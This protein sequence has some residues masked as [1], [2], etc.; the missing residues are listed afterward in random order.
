VSSFQIVIPMSGFGERFRRAG[1]AVPKPLIE[2]EGKPIIAHVVDMFPG[3]SD[4]LFICNEDHLADPDYRMAEI[5]KT[6]CPNGRVVGIPVHRLGPVHAVRQVEHMIDPCRPVIVNYCD[7]TCYWDWVH[8]KH[9]V[10]GSACA[11]AL[12][13]YKGF[14]PH[15]LGTTNYA[16]ICESDGWAFDIQEKQPF[17]ANRMEE[18]ASSGTYYF[19]SGAIMSRAFAAMVE[20]NLSLNGEYYVSLA[21]KPLMQS[22]E[23]IAVYELQHFMQWGTP[24]DVAEYNAWSAAFRALAAEQTKTSLCEVDTALRVEY[25]TKQR[26]GAD[27]RFGLN[28]SHSSVEKAPTGALVVPLAGL[29]ARFAREGYETPKPL[30]PVSG[31][32]MVVQA[33]SDLPRAK[34]HAFVLRSDMAGAAEVADLL[35]QT[36]PHSSIVM[37]GDVTEG[38]A[39][40]ALIGLGALTNFSGPVTFCACDNGVLYDAGAF[41]QLQSRGGADVIVWAARGHPHAARYPE[42][43]GWIDANEEGDIRAISVKTPLGSP[44]TDPIVI[45]AFTFRRASDVMRCIGRLIEREGRINGEFYLD[46]CINDA[47][48]LGLSCRLFEVDHYFSWG[49]PNDLK[50]FE[51]WQSCFHKWPAHP[52]RLEKDLRVDPAKR[53]MLEARFAAALP[54]PPSERASA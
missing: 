32:P 54:P 27:G 49:T 20:Q 12:P 7:F 30:I 31:G 48:E 41:A 24:E 26:D 28:E 15:S 34:A 10:R 42:M 40:S 38:Q 17:T 52:Y 47:L 25:A 1:Y 4:F 36:F 14:H 13:A 37:L 21:Y 3:E 53:A 19:R 22:N 9:F 46:S 51:Y 6:Y 16:Y 2:I 33:V 11:G 5:I 35:R 43:Y 39:C 29:G 23:P 8:F 44:A 18:Y 45:G 50:T